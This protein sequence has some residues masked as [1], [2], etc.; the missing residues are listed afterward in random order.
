MSRAE[1]S[2]QQSFECDGKKFAQCE[3]AEQLFR[4]ANALEGKCGNCPE[5]PTCPDCSD[6]E[7]GEEPPSGVH[8]DWEAASILWF[9]P[10][11]P[12]QAVRPRGDS[13][14]PWIVYGPSTKRDGFPRGE[15]VLLIDA[16]RDY[17]SKAPADIEL[18]SGVG[19]VDPE[20]HAL[21]KWYREMPSTGPSSIR[22][23]NRDR[24]HAE[25]YRHPGPP[26]H[27]GPFD[28]PAEAL[29]VMKSSVD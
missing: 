13:P 8:Q 29:K 22:R 18:S 12:T 3:I 2:D 28:N 17:N 27:Q 23:D 21:L 24:F 19:T 16:I 14:T 25:W 1:A 15:G 5:P 7:D 26:Q 6:C 9:G 10:T 4:I 11:K 20:L